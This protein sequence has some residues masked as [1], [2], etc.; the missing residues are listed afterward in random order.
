MSDLEPLTLATALERWA[1]RHEKVLHLLDLHAAREARSLARACRDLHDWPKRC[2][3]SD[4]EIACVWLELRERV[5]HLLHATT[6]RERAAGDPSAAPQADGP[7]TAS[8]PRPGRR[9]SMVAPR[10]RVREAG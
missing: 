7:P 6:E 4:L 1:F 10:G 3:V 2:R 5:A 8:E 9:D